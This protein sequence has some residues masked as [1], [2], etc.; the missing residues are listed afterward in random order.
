[1]PSPVRSAIVATANNSTMPT[2]R[3]WRRAVLLV[4]AR[5]GLW[6]TALAQARRTVRRRWWR[7]RPFLP[8]P[9]RRYLAWRLRTQYGL[10]GEPAP[11]DV[12]SYLDWCRAMARNRRSAMRGH[13]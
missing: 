1:V 8:L 3:F 9:D 7:H 10:D 12:V 5:P 13:R 2:G 4:G 6:P 11:A